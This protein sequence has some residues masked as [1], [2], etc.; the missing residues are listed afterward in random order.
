MTRLLGESLQSRG[1]K[2]LTNTCVMHCESDSVN[3]IDV[4]N[5]S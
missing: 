1:W 2:T 3:V 4:F 5:V